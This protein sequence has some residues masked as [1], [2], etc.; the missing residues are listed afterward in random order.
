MYTDEQMK[1]LWDDYRA[2]YRQWDAGAL[3]L[4]R[5]KVIESKAV[6]GS[7]PRRSK[8]QDDEYVR[9]DAELTVLDMLIAERETAARSRKVAQRAE[10]IREI[11]RAAMDPANRAG[12]A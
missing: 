3:T 7:Y 12:R 9:L 4:R 6:L 11:S 8:T 2:E 10:Q 5:G 1:D